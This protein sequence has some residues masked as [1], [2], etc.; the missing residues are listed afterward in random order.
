MAQQETAAGGVVELLSTPYFFKALSLLQ[1]LQLNMPLS[2]G[3]IKG[4]SIVHH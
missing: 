3:Q 4:I 2:L 1:R